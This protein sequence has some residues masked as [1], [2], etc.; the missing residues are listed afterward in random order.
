MERAFHRTSGVPPHPQPLSRAGERG[1]DILRTRECTRHSS[2]VTRHFQFIALNLLALL[3]LATSTFAAE[4]SDLSPGRSA[5]GPERHAGVAGQL[6][7]A[8]HHRRVL[9][10][11]RESGRR[12]GF[13]GGRRD[14]G[15]RRKDDLDGRLQGRPDCRATL[16]SRG[17][18]DA[19]TQFCEGC[20]SSVHDGRMRRL[21]LSWLNPRSEGFQAFSV[22]LRARDRLRGDS[23]P[24]RSRQP[25]KEP[26]PDQTDIPDPAWRRAAICGGIFGVSNHPGMDSRRCHL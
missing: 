8:R 21:Q 23:A 2:L 10:P 11:H 20:R 25:R 5:P 4:V 24:H 12:F 1:A 3:T 22:W 13:R 9:V 17:W 15:S 14:S 26:G 16:G 18:R 6:R 7:P 19:Q